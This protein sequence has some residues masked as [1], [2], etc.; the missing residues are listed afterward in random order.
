M[1]SYNLIMRAHKAP[2]GASL[3]VRSEPAVTWFRL[4]CAYK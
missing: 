3:M 2:N 4:L 1:Y